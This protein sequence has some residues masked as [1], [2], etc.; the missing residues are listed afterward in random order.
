MPAFASRPEVLVVQEAPSE[1]V[2][3]VPPLPVTTKV[4]FPNPTDQRRVEDP[5]VLV[6]QVTP[7]EDVNMA[8]TSPTATKV[9]F[10][11]VTPLR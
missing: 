7:S 10:P 8:P 1:D 11:K 2:N 3:M 4:L 5:E 9:L 6:A